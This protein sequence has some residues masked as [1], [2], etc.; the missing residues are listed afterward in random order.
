MNAF[1]SFDRQMRLI[2]KFNGVC[3][4]LEE[5]SKLEIALKELQN[6]SPHEVLQFWGKISGEDADYFIALGINFTNHFEFPQK[7]FYYATS[8][9]FT[10]EPLPQT[11]P[12]HDV[13]MNKTYYDPLKGNP[14][15]LIK[16]MKQEAP[17]GTAEPAEKTP[18][19]LAKEEAQR[20]ALQEEIQLLKAQG[21]DDEDI[22]TSDD[23][24]TINI[25]K[26]KQEEPK[27]N[28]TEKMKLSYIVRQIDHDTS[29]IPQGA[30]MLN[31][32]HEVHVSN[33]FKG[34]NKDELCDLSK[35]MHFRPVTNTSIK[36]RMKDDDALFH[37]DIFDSIIDD[38]VKGSWSVVTD[39]TKTTCNIR[40]LLWPGYYAVHVSGT[41]TYCGVYFGNGMKNV[42]LPFMI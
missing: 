25:D 40:S 22:E 30:L 38:E 2:S 16:Q 8:T 15:L 32:K 20:K 18:E 27:D 17:E 41:N 11:L 12:Y 29:I 35:W 10:F 6:A 4:N 42:D 31:N 26:P 14:N 13:E 21:Y 28:F 7:V 34:L 39:T 23:L 9:T 3:L 1:D 36:E 33:S 5:R 37:K 24:L 19:E